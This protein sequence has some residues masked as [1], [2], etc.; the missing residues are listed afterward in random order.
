MQRQMKTYSNQRQKVNALGEKAM[1]R[2]KEAQDHRR[3]ILELEKE[4]K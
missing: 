1:A 4:K 3:K 2:L